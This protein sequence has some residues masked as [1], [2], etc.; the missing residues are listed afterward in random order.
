MYI[1]LVDEDVSEHDYLAEWDWEGSDGMM[2]FILPLDEEQVITKSGMYVYYT[3]S[4][5]F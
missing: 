3:V 5:L 1:Q 4:P 2:D